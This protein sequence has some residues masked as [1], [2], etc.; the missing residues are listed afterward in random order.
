MGVG[1]LWDMVVGLNESECNQASAG[2]SNTHDAQL[3]S[4][5]S[6]CG[7]RCPAECAITAEAGFVSVQRCAGG[8]STQHLCVG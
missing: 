7:P 3:L 8:A 2:Q 1:G 4:Q 6:E 5:R